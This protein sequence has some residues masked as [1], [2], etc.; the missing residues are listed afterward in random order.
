MS[1]RSSIFG[2]LGRSTSSA[3]ASIATSNE[4]D[5]QEI[6]GKLAP[7]P[8]YTTV[9]ESATADLTAAF[10]Q[11][12]LSN[13]ASDP[14]VET[15][16]AHLKLL[17]AIQSIKEEVGYTDGLWGLWDALAGP[18]DQL[19]HAYADSKKTPSDSKKPFGDGPTEDEEKTAM[20]T[21]E[22]LSKI[23]EKRWALFLARATQRYEAWWKSLPG[24]PLTE[25]DMEEDTSYGYEAFPTDDSATFDWSEDKLPPLGTSQALLR[26]FVR[27]SDSCLLPPANTLIL[28]RCSDGLAYPYAQPPCL[29]RRCHAS[30]LERLLEQRTPV[31]LDQRGYRLGL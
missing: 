12:S 3:T 23:R 22:N 30:W 18:L 10:D 27:I 26:R 24:Q 8:A 7:P 21:L 4:K 9:D 16:L 25:E 17:F 2:R 28:H 15:C 1:R 6:D 20:K 14:T 11:L 29:P 31:A 13:A 5:G 19:E